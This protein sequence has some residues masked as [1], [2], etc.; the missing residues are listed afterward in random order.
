MAT[1]VLGMQ[2][3][4]E[5]KGKI[6]HLLAREAKMVVRF[7]GGPN[8]GHTVIDRGVKFGTHQIPAGAF[9]PGVMSVLAGGMVIDLAVLRDEYSTIV[10]HLGGEPELLIADN[11]HLIMPY[12]RLLEDLEGS[13]KTIGTTRRGI[14]PAYRDRAARIGIRAI[15]LLNRAR[16]EKKLSAR[17]ALLRRA[18][19][20]AESIMALSAADIADELLSFAQPFLPLIGDASM[21]IE[22]AMASGDEVLFEGAQ[23]AL[24]DVDY[25]TYPYVTSSSTVYAGLPHAIGIG[26]LSVGNRLGVTKAYTTRVGEGPFPTELVGEDGSWLQ[27]AGSEFGVTTGRPRRCG[28]LDVVALRHVTRLNAPTGLAITKLDILTG[29]QEIKVCR[30]YRLRGREIT[31]FPTSVEDL[32]LCEP[33]YETLHGWED[34]ISNLREYADL[35]VAAREYLN[36]LSNAL[37]VPIAL[38]SVGPSPEKTIMTGF[39]RG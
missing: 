26:N 28:W 19:P 39:D 25:G 16:L 2:W 8:A 23:G 17:L 20:Q 18:W 30:A 34:D 35:P 4:D 29:L 24:L 6:T 7:N 36:M 15:D 33:V 27:R 10:K 14:G 12:H 37:D 38:V 32:A 1:A 3:G 21:A 22:Q 11:A 9:Y 31:T 5:G 13:G